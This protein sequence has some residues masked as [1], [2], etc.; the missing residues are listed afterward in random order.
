MA[1]PKIDQTEL[2]LARE[3]GDAL[4]RAYV[5]PMTRVPKGTFAEDLYEFARKQAVRV[6]NDAREVDVGEKEI[7][8]MKNRMGR[9][10]KV[11]MRYDKDFRELWA[12]REMDPK[13]RGEIVAEMYRERMRQRVEIFG[14]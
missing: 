2:T 6:Q 10:I 7:A 14:E 4:A 13:A 8:R 11:I 3:E 5:E 1:E 9:W 12:N